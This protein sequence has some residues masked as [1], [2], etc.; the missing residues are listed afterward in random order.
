MAIPA[1]LCEQLVFRLVGKGC[2]GVSQLS[3]S[4][5]SLLCHCPCAAEHNIAMSVPKPD[6]LNGL[7][8]HRF[9]SVQKRD[10]RLPVI[11]KYVGEESE[12]SSKH[13]RAWEHGIHP[14]RLVRHPYVGKK[15]PKCYRPKGKTYVV[16]VD[17][18]P[19]GKQA[20]L[21]LA[22]E[23]GIPTGREDHIGPEHGDIPVYCCVLIIL[24]TV[25]MLYKVSFASN[26]EIGF[27]QGQ[28]MAT[29]TGSR[30][31]SVSWCVTLGEH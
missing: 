26:P 7:K 9:P 31:L 11:Y 4:L 18:S 21:D 30:M 17:T 24:I 22:R 29:D 27:W 8:L 1:C 23:L 2:S 25:S 14:Q 15:L 13:K 12:I 6:I 16:L 10:R 20:E 3:L 19:D 28:R 5:P